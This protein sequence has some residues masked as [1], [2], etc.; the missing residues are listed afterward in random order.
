MKPNRFVFLF[1]QIDTNRINARQQLPSMNQLEKW[2]ADG[3]IKMDMSAP[4]FHEA[5]AGGS[6][7]RSAKTITY[8][9]ADPAITTSQEELRR[10]AI[11]RILF[12]AG[13]RSQNEQNDVSVVF[14]A[15]KYRRILVTNDGGSRKQP[16][17]IL[18]NVNALAALGIEVLSDI[19]AVG[20]VREAIAFRDAHARKFSSQTGEPLPDWVDKD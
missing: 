12:P 16:D 1:F 6:G 11:E 18:G 20:R 3:V 4:A 7:L 19:A 15:D 9:F 13:A 2:K 5:L 10:N 8:M 14:T 17:G